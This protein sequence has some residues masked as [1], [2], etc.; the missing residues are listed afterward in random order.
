MIF[1]SVFIGAKVAQG[2]FEHVLKFLHLKAW[3]WLKVEASPPFSS[4]I[5]I[6]LDPLF[7]SKK[8]HIVATLSAGDAERERE[9]R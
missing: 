1:Y 9:N 5:T 7:P 3:Q 2:S 6:V 8:K 4:R